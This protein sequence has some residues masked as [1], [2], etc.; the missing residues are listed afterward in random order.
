MVSSPLT[1][2]VKS[3]LKLILSKNENMYMHQKMICDIVSNKEDTLL[4]KEQRNIALIGSTEFS[5]TRLN[6]I[7]SKLVIGH[8]RA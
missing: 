8:D 4:R 1:N 3:L 2:C 5:F 7:E 6:V